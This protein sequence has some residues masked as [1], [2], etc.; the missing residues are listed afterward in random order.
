MS[1]KR[2]RKENGLIFDEQDECIYASVDD[3]IDL[4]NSFCDENEQLKKRVK[5]LEIENMRLKFIKDNFIEMME[6]KMVMND[7]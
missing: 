7:E 2:F 5:E 1:E 3:V 4:L 6:S